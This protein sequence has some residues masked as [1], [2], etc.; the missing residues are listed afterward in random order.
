MVDNRRY[1]QRNRLEG[2]GGQAKIGYESSW[3]ICRIGHESSAY[4]LSNQH[5]KYDTLDTSP[6]IVVKNKYTTV[7]TVNL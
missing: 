7:N 2:G 5:G 6:K 3:Y 1:W 4:P